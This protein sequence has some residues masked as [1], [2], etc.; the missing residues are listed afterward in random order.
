MLLLYKPALYSQQPP[1]L[2]KDHALLALFQGRNNVTPSLIWP[3]QILQDIPNLL[4][5]Q[6]PQLPHRQQESYSPMEYPN[7]L[8]PKNSSPTL[9]DS[10]HVVFRQN[11]HSSLLRM[12]GSQY[13]RTH[14]T[15]FART[16]NFYPP[17]TSSKPFENL[18]LLIPIFYIIEGPVSVVCSLCR[19]SS[20]ALPSTPHSFI[21]SE[22]SC[23]QKLCLP[24]I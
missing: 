5:S 23:F 17:C 20:P 16:C 21:S 4:L 9:Q 11:P 13:P 14:C 2:M 12:L 18:H 8:P 24:P 15:L 3:S 19:Q 6:E 1:T 7:S 10:H 22:N